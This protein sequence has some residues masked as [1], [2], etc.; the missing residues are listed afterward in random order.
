MELTSLRAGDELDEDE[1]VQSFEIDSSKVEAS[2]ESGG[3]PLRGRPL[4]MGNSFRRR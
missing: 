1:T 4:L 2:I 3:R